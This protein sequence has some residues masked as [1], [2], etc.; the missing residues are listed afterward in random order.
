LNSL[1]AGVVPRTGLEYIAIGRTD[2][3]SAILSDLQ[4]VESGGSAF[5][6]ISGRYGSGKS[7]LIQLM[8]S[9]AMERG[10]AV[11]DADLSPERRLTGAKGQGL[12]TYRELMRN[13]ST[14]AAPDGGALSVLLTRWISRLQVAAAKK[15]GFAP[16]SQALADAV[17]LE[18][19]EVIAGLEVLVH[20]FDFATAVRCFYRGMVS[21]DDELRGAALRW[22]RGEF[23]TKTEARKYLPVSG[24]IEDASW[25]DYLKLVGALLHAAGQSGF[26]IFIDE[27]VNLY[28]IVQS[29]SRES[30]YEILLNIFNDCTQGKL[31]N[32]AFVFGATPQCV[33]DRRRGL[34]S[35][36]AL[37][38]RL[39]GSRFAQ[40]GIIDMSEPVIKLQPLTPEEIL[41]L[42]KR[43]LFIHAS[44]YEWNPGV[45]DAQIAVLVQ[46]L[47]GRMGAETLL[48]P[49]EVVRDFTGLLNILRQNP[50]ESFETLAAKLDIKPADEGESEARTSAEFAE[51]EL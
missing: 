16:G 6:L 30:N 21:G 13:L 40:A 46:N 49:R 8:R 26:I 19:M 47:A 7:F 50:A 41:A 23:A 25:Y 31:S 18:I 11:A 34:Y 1:A 14:R 39:A 33:E 32:M 15:H 36:E 3:I 5:R 44:H 24:I 9:H 37:R 29:I 22:M 10:F 17:E 12:A 42:L 20:G 51:F 27:T 38:S 48:T 2:E 35:Y 43:I 45:T 28:K 4:V